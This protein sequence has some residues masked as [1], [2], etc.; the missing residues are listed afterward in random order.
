M[1]A[2]YKR[3]YCVD[4]KNYTVT[5][6]SGRDSLVRNVADQYNKRV[7]I[8]PNDTSFEVVIDVRGQAW[9]QEMLD[10]I[11]HRIIEQTNGNMTVS[12]MN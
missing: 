1:V 10:D 4:I 7:L 12:F 8:F 6:Q 5:T 2:E 9:T 3:N 11:T